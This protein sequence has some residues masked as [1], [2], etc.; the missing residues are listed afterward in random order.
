MSERCWA[1]VPA[2]GVG[3]RMGGATPKQYLELLG[4]KV[5]DHSL[6]RLLDHPRIEAAYVALAD[7]DDEWDGTGHAGDTRVVRVAGGAERCHSVLNALHALATRAAADD[8]VLVHDA[9]RPCLSAADLDLLIRQLK[10]HPVGGLLGTPVQD[11]LKRVSA[12]GAVEATVPRRDLWQAYTPQMFRLGLLIEA[13]EQ[14]LARGELVTDDASAME[15]AG[16]R[17]LMVEGH[18]GNIKITRPA[19]LALAAFYLSLHQPGS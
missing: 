14:A 12:D 5:I 17:P 10:D 18:A 16:H 15:L 9:A 6:Q 3:R 11:T 19:D 8:W 1:V 13:L 2:A 4:R 7:T